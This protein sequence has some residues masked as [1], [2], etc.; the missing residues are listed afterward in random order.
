[1]SPISDRKKQKV[2]QGKALSAPEES[3]YPVPQDPPDC[4]VLQAEERARLCGGVHVR[5]CDAGDA[6]DPA[7]CEPG[8]PGVAGARVTLEGDQFCETKVATASSDVV[9]QGL[10]A[11]RYVARVAP[12]PHYEVL[13]EDAQTL[14]VEDDGGDAFAVFSLAAEPA[15][16]A[17]VAFY[18][19]AGNGRPD[20]QPR[21]AGAAFEL[22]QDGAA[23]G[24]A[25]TDGQGIARRRI[26]PGTVLIASQDTVRLQGG[27]AL[28][29]V[30]REAFYV[31][32]AAGESQ[33]IAVGYRE[34]LG[35]I[36]ITAVFVD[37][38][39][40]EV[41]IPF[42]GVALA[43]FRGS[44]Q[45]GAPRQT[46][47]AAAI[48]FSGLLADLY[49][50]R[51]TLP[52]TFRGQA[53]ALSDADD[54]EITFHVSAS[55]PS[56]RTIRCGPALGTV[57]GLVVTQTAHQGL[58]GIPA[59]LTH[60]TGKVL[61]TTTGA[62]GELTFRGVL[63]GP[64]ILELSPKAQTADGQRWE[65]AP[66]APGRQVVVSQPGQVTTA[67]PIPI[68]REE[69]AIHVTAL[70]S[71]GKPIPYALILVSDVQHRPVG[72]GRFSANKD[73]EALIPVE[74]AGTYL[75]SLGV[76]ETG[77]PMRGPQPIEVNSI[78]DMTVQAPGQPPPPTK[79]S[80]GLQDAVVDIPYPLLTESVPSAGWSG[81]WP[82]QPPSGADLGQTVQEALRSVLN[83]RPAGFNGDAK[84]FVA[85]LNQSFTL[86]QIEGHTELTWTPRSYAAVQSGLGA[87]TGAQA[88]IYTRAKAALDQV[89][90]LLEGLYPLRADADPQD[91]AAIR[92]IVRSGLNE[93][94]NE[95]GIEGGPRVL[96]TDDLFRQLVGSAGP[97]VNPDPEQVGGQL[98]Q[99]SKLFGLER[100]RVNTIDE[101]QNLTNFLIIADY[102]LGL[103]QS[104]L[105]QRRF[106]TRGSGSEPFLGTQLV[107]VERALSVVAES[108]QEVYLAMDSVFLG[109]EERQVV[110]LHYSDG[111]SLFVAEL[112][113]WIDQVAANEGPQLIKD[114]GKQGV[115]SFQPTVDRLAQLAAGALLGTIEDPD[116]L[117]AGYRTARVQRAL[118]ELADHLAE[119]SNLVKQFGQRTA[120]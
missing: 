120:P 101:E 95:L 115:I 112:L 86:R 33:T 7:P 108:V 48:V 50:L 116:A 117:P 59:L 10:R 75:V 8:S 5:V 82:G 39:Q 24:C 53:V 109:K 20:G 31:P 76:F 93:L 21:I 63:P 74:E 96:R 22:S 85:A 81:S 61:S 107:L 17:L 73:G 89:I 60:G 23:I 14:E 6:Q 54:S 98:Q 46:Q 18:D 80:S 65:L 27:R 52:P 36:R 92:A 71:D 77:L 35:E 119:A 30:V 67:Q 9:W 43:L 32:L 102:T 57:V 94:V 72:P 79:R 90:P 26:P 3:Y 29:S 15:D 97:T 106:F 70:G 114:G 83:W 51:V 105:T 47:G 111:T 49:T 69:H 42:A 28:R 78:A 113:G 34:E 11:G 40:P 55:K 19:R 2:T 37:P 99:L 64:N 88:S 12:P 13:G 41:E 84:G 44:S 104:W 1:M 110:E 16:L 66:G 56:E 45:V 118:Q 58:D 25:V 87:L 4:E 103:Q 91:T 62:C 38:G 100:T 68:V